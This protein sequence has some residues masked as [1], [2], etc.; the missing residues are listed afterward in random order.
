M[1]DAEVTGAIERDLYVDAFADQRARPVAYKGGAP[2]ERLETAIYTCP[3]C[4]RVGTLV[5]EGDRFGC[6]CGLSVRYGAF[7]F[8]EGARVP[9]DTVAEWD[10]WQ[11]RRLRELIRSRG[12]G[13]ICRKEDALL[14]RIDAKHGETAVARGALSLDATCLRVGAFAVPTEKV[15]GMA[16]YGRGTIVFSAGGD[17]Y[18]LKCAR[19]VNM[20]KYL[21]L[22]QILRETIHA[23]AITPG[24]DD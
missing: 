13:V 23:G 2:A 20:R 15:G 14:T 16:M 8:F 10:L 6:A 11:E 19:G 24:G 7:G 18:E 17:S 5:S 12:S 1:T 21:T 9:F 4:G 22:F 3:A